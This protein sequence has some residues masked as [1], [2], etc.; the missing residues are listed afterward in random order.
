MVS[1]TACWIGSDVDPSKV[2]SLM[3][4]RMMTR[5]ISGFVQATAD[6]FTLQ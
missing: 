2:M 4:V 1:L 3:M 6:T 5:F